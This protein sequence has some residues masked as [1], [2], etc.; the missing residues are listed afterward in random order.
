MQVTLGLAAPVFHGRVQRELQP[1][2]KPAAGGGFT[3]VIAPEYIDRPISLGFQLVTAAGGGNRQ[4]GLQLLDPHGAFVAAVPVASV[5]AG[6]LTWKY[7]FL[8]QLNSPSAVQAGVVISP[9]FAEL[10]YPDYQLV[11]SV[12]GAAG[13]DQ[14][15]AVMYDA[16]R[17][18]TGP[19]GY[20]VGGHDESKLIARAAERA[21]R[22]T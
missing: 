18:S 6:G 13:G 10:I 8:A 12:G 19:D 22:L 3:H 17:F 5:Q 16:D 20:P 7:S 11:V 2:P 4:V 1:L 15:S 21:A 9:M 14:I